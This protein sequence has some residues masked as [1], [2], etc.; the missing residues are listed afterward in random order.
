[1]AGG[2]LKVGIIQCVEIHER[3]RLPGSPEAW[4]RE[5]GGPSVLHVAGR[6]S[7]R[8]RAV[9]TLLHGNEP[10]GLRAVHAW[11]RSGAEP[12][13]NAFLFL[14][15]VET[16]LAEPVFSHRF[17]PGR[18]D[19]N[20][21]F[22]PPFAARE[23]EI[24]GDLLERLRKAGPEA[25]L[26]IHN[27]TGHNPPY[28]VGPRAGAP[29]LN[30]VALFGHRYVHS[31]LQ[32]GAVIESTADDFPSVTVECG[33]AGDPAA[34]AVALAGLEAFLGQD[35]LETEQRP[36]PM[37]LFTDPVRVA[38][39]PGLRLA[40]GEGPA[41]GADLTVTA[42]VDRHNFDTLAPGTAIGWLGASG[43]WPILA[44]TSHGEDHSQ[45][46]FAARGGVLETRRPIVPIMM[47][48]NPDVALADCLFYLV[49][50]TER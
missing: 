29:E 31:D 46:L 50:P 6:D 9:S 2:G 25:F 13:V 20:R 34:D 43:V 18:R 16:A 41:S 30:L 10:S 48:T 35:Q 44:S 39:R 37:Q 5:L 24:A 45:E 38:M 27:N 7:S 12:A 32:L 33:R 3:G 42:D 47:T 36:E 22:R 4:L 49:Q 28:G 19:L 15:A 14:G 17:L 21:C 23:G 40:F 1:M 11:L 26:D 8:I